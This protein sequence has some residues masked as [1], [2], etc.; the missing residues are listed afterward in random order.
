ML[1]AQTEIEL[2]DLMLERDPNDENNIV[3]LIN[4]FVYRNHQCLVFEMLSYNLYELLKNTR[5]S[6][7]INLFHILFKV[8][9]LL[10]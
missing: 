3:R 5:Y 10:T 4:R 8:I 6:I 9:S 2:L 7:L 1:Q